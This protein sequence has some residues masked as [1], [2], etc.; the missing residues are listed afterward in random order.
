MRLTAVRPRFSGHETFACRFAWLPKAVRLIARDPKALSDDD[1]AILELGLGKNMVRA[2]RFWL[3]A[4]DVA[5]ADA[6]AW[7]LRPFGEAL[8][9]NGGLDP[10]IERVETQWLLHWRLS[11]AVENPLFAWRH[12]LYRRMRPDFTRSELLVEI[13][14][15]GERLGY[16]HSDITLLQ[17]ADVFI[18][19]YLGS[20]NPA[21]PEDALDGPLVDLGLLRRLGRRRGAD[22]IEPVFTLTRI[23]IGEIGGAVVDYAIASYWTARRAGESVVSFRDLA[24]GEGSPGATLRMETDDLRDYLERSP[25]L[26]SYRPSG[27]AGSVMAVADL[28]PARLLREIYA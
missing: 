1:R 22:R 4:F 19:S 14:N 13:R 23:P 8:F 10:F 21:S 5:S 2:L 28:S 16:E 11:T 15:E 26:W 12:I 9:G 3:E 6:G 7:S 18:H 24:Y 27:D 25:A 20:L 17:H